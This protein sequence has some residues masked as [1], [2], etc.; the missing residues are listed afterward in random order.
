M[1]GERL[2]RLSPHPAKPLILEI[3][4][5]PGWHHRAKFLPTSWGSWCAPQG[6][7]WLMRL[8]KVWAVLRSQNQPK[9]TPQP[10]GHT[11]Y[12]EKFPGA[13][14]P[15]GRQSTVGTL[16]HMSM[17]HFGR[18]RNTIHSCPH[19]VGAIPHLACPVHTNTR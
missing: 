12:W 3:V 6:L 17:N 13:V 2:P 15:C 8:P 19:H 18:T 9:Q 14:C 11:N 5:V 1:R 4:G 10:N 7:Y 16:T